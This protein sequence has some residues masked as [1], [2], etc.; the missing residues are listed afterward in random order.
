MRVG[1]HLRP[2]ACIPLYNNIN[3]PTDRP[4]PIEEVIGIMIANVPIIMMTMAHIIDARETCECDL[5][6]AEVATSLLVSIGENY[7]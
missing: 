4:I 2:K 1:P 3:R 5:F 7:S 6:L